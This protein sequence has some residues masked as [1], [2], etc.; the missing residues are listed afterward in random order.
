MQKPVHLAFLNAGQLKGNTNLAPRFG[1]REATLAVHEGP[2]A[3]A[4][5]V[6]GLRIVFVG[7]DAETMS[8]S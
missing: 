1:K 6:G 2:E 4:L 7:R 8:E 3:S 5:V